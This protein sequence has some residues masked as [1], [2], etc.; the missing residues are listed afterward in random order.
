M[1]DTFNW[2]SQKSKCP[3]RYA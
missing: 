3:F 1:S 2:F